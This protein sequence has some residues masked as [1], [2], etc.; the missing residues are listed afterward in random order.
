MHFV[1][2][3]CHVAKKNIKFNSTVIVGLNKQLSCLPL[4]FKHSVYHN[5]LATCDV[6]LYKSIQHL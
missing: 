3:C 1:G 6:K 4:S 2:L 5:H